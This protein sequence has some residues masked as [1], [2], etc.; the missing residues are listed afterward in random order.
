VALGKPYSRTPDLITQSPDRRWLL[1]QQTDIKAPTFDMYDVND[2]TLPATQV[3]IPPSILTNPNAD[4]SKLTLVEW[5]N[6]NNNVLLQHTTGGSSE[7]VVF[8]KA[9]PAKSFNINSVFSVNPTEVALRDKKINQV[10]IYEAANQYLRIGDV[11]KKTI[12]QPLAS[13]VLAFKSAG[14]NLIIYVTSAGMTSGTVQARIY[15]GGNTYPLYAFNAGSAYVINAARFSGDWYY[16]AGSDSDEQV[17]IFKNPLDDLKNSSVGKATPMIGFRMLGA[18][19]AEFSANTRFLGVQAGQKIGVYDF[20]EETR[21]EYDAPAA[22]SAPLQWMDGH[23]FI[24]QADGNVV[25]FDYD[26]TNM[27][28]LVGT[29]DPKGGY[30]SRSYNQLLTLSPNPDGKTVSL[31]HTDMRAGDDLP[32]DGAP[33]P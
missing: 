32:K 3:A 2:L 24:G 31:V 23:R 13:H 27:Q 4:D 5:S 29:V 28:S 8:D 14:A 19:K 16:V 6:D 12:G 25:V 33:T 11:S 17:D 20:E 9:D 30:F 22:I 18:T 26:S 21:Y 15:D 1:V 10:Y 7:F